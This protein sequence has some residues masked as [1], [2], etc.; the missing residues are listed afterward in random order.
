MK[1]AEEN[2]NKIETIASKTGDSK[3]IKI[4]WGFLLIILAIVIVIQAGYYGFAIKNKSSDIMTLQDSIKQ[5]EKD[6]QQLIDPDSGGDWSNVIERNNEMAKQYLKIA[7]EAREKSINKLENEIKR[8]QIL[9]PVLSASGAAFA[10]VGLI[11][12]LKNIRRR[13]IKTSSA[14]SEE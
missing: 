4:V 2:Y 1:I 3:T 8:A 5:Y 10:I 13:D 11:L 9:L 7:A 12:I 14:N 6:E